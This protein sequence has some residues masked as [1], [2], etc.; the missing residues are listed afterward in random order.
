VKFFRFLLNCLVLVIVLVAILV[1]MAFAPVVQTWIAQ[2]VL[3]RQPGLQGTL[4][5]LW[6]GFGKVNVA[7]LQLKIDGAD[8]KVPS[9]KAEL[10]LTTAL[11]NRRFL[12]RRLVAKGWTLDL[13]QV[14]APKAEASTGSASAA[15]EAQGT[16]APANSVS[17]Q[18][19][20][21]LIYGT[22]SHWKLPCD[23]S[24]DGVDLEGDV[25][26]AAI[27]GTEP[28]RVHVI[29]K[30]GGIAAGREGT[31]AIDASGDFIDKDASMISLAGHGQVA[32]A[33]MSPRTF[34]RVEVKADLSTKGGLVPEGL[35]LSA[36]IA[37]ALDAREETFSLELNRGDQHLAT[38][39]ARFPE[40]TS[41]LAGTWKID[42]QDSDVAL[43]APN[44]SLPQFSAKGGGRFDCDAALTQVHAMG[45]LGGAISHLGVLAPS[46]ERFG[47]VTVDADFDA[48]R[49]NQSIRVDRL[50]ASLAGAGP[51]A[52]ARSLQ[53]FEIDQHI[54]DLKPLNPTGDWMD[55]SI[56][57]FPLAW[58]SD[59]TSGIAF[60]GGNASGAFIVRTAKGGFTLRSQAPVTAAGVSVQRTG[61][62]LGQKLDLALSLLAEYGS[63]GWQAEAAPLTISSGG[64]LLAKFDGKASRPAGPDQPIAIVGAWNSDLQTLASADVGPNLSWIRGRSASGD[65]SAKVGTSVDLDGKLSV[66][67]G[68]KRNTI[69]GSLHA[70]EDETGRIT[71]LAPVKVAF[72]STASDLSVEGTS[73][74]DETGARLY[75]K[76]TGKDVS[77]EH[78][79]WLAASLAE[80]G[81]AT[82]TASA[83]TDAPA[84][85]PDRIPFWG[86]WSGNVAVAFARLTAGEYAFDDVGGA[87]QLNHGSIRLEGGHGGLAGQR[88][89]NVEG[90]IAF[91]ADAELPYGV[92]VTASLNRVEATPLFPVPKSG[93]DPIIEGVFSV[94]GTLT[95]KGRNLG[96]LVGRTQEEFRLTSQAGIVR[97]LKT[98]VDEA[99]P[100][101][102]VS[103]VSDTLGRVGSGVGTFFGVEDNGRSDR[104][105]VNPTAEAVLEFIND[106]SE[107]GFDEV[108]MTAV[109]E[110]DR[111]IRIMSVEMTAGDE[112]LTGS[113]QITAVDGL[114]LRTEPLSVDLQFWAR[115][116]IAKLLSK[117]GLLSTE[118]DSLGYARLNQPI[119][120]GGT[121][122][123]IDRSQWHNML[124]KAAAQNP[125]EPKKKP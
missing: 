87:F 30:G 21:R 5:S 54:G 98:D 59:S 46:M 109:R 111:T 80:A 73:I 51:A 101:E 49:S 1:A 39:L 120:L 82:A 68:D 67:G 108:T 88:F 6:A 90:S 118:K 55:I 14:S 76:L 4:G 103:S 12:V 64:R 20:V 112:R 94:A 89:A 121:L 123:H 41:G 124:V 62:T 42:L 79:R 19:M 18:D 117:A 28:I 36:D 119:H 122:E 116:R 61:K 65:F 31:F 107:I 110:P 32:I 3:A 53:S 15:P 78:L 97:V 29:V 91:D 72:G 99:F 33:M 23:V 83:G 93:G 75:V 63:E 17:A 8:L 69:T 57:G 92:K 114:S 48:T 2:A 16:P 27:A 47:S 125:G 22:L 104:K 81:G 100:S 43:F 74:R 58:L 52:V 102:K 50:N 85:V 34:R 95:G 9:L 84:L 106:V 115:G 77:F 13:H 66:V 71:F 70:E 96:D 7:E 37:A 26:V 60:S 24:L 35:T 25:L 38:V 11:L 45:H 105:S 113:G 40:G 56:R 10:S 44:R 86:D